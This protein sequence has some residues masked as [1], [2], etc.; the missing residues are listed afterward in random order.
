MHRGLR[1]SRWSYEEIGS[2]KKTHK[3]IKSDFTLLRSVL[4]SN[5]LVGSAGQNQA[6]VELEDVANVA[7]ELIDLVLLGRE[8]AFFVA[9]NHG[10]GTQLADP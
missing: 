4:R 2:G 8:P 5:E 3:N 10:V 1:L 7:D 9:Q 6:H